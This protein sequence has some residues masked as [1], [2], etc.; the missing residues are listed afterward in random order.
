M[1]TYQLKKNKWKIVGVWIGGGRRIYCTVETNRQCRWRRGTI[2]GWGKFT[3]QHSTILLGI[4]A[5]LQVKSPVDTVCKTSFQK[6]DV[7]WVE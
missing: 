2:P 7:G 1:K 4:F 6:E 5:F 3:E